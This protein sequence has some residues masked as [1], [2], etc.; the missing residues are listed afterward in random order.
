MNPLVP[1]PLI[2]YEP[3]IVAEAVAHYGFFILKKRAL[4]LI[5]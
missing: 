5:I 2:R 3:K 1:P 4:S